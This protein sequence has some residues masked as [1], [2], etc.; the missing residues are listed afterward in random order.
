[1]EAHVVIAT[2]IVERCLKVAR[3]DFFL[4]FYFIIIIIIII[5]TLFIKQKYVTILT[6]NCALR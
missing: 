4:F 2:L 1:M 3:E 6:Y 5:S